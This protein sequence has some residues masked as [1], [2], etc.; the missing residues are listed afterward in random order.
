MAVVTR[1]RRLKEGSR[2]AV[3][4]AWMKQFEWFL[5]EASPKGFRINK[6]VLHHDSVALGRKGHCYSYRCSRKIKNKDTATPGTIPALG[7]KALQILS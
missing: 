5:C 6:F 4:E 3:H 2:I 1:Q 7:T